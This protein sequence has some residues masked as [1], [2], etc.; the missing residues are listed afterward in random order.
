MAV[1]NLGATIAAENCA[2]RQAVSDALRD[3][4]ANNT[5]NTQMI[6]DKLCQQEID[7]L[8]AQNANLQ[9]QLV[10]ANLAASQNA[11]TAAIEAGQRALANEV[12]QYV[13]PTA[14]PAYIVQNPNCCQNFG[15]GCGCGN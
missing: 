5:A 6:I 3:V 14:R 2:D 9:N 1:A 12:E 13:L 8:K 15:Y 10:M 11:Q 4:I 7:A